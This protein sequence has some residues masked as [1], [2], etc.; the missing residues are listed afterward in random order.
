M[1]SLQSDQ[2]AD[3]FRAV[4]GHAPF[5]WQRRF[6]GEVLSKGFHDAVRVPTGCG[7]TSIL[8]IAV[9]HLALDADRKPDKRTAA[10]RLCFVIDRRLVVDEVTEHAMRILKAVQAAAC[11]TRNE[12]TLK[13]VAGR[14]AGLAANPD[15]PLRVVRLRGGVYREDAWATD[16]LTPSLI[17]S[18]V[19][20]IGRLLFRGYGVSPRSQPL[21]AGLL[22]FDAR[23]ILDEAHLSNVFGRASSNRKIGKH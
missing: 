19:D 21:Q 10:R 11:G 4:H 1:A 17:V 20:Q 23:I 3:F 15:E 12:P 6:A 13:A 22:A 2:F 18:T 16:P 9:F 14:L 5:D 8:D 7:K